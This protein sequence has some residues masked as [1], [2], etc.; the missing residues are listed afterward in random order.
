M[1]QVY[2]ATMIKCLGLRGSIADKLYT[3]MEIRKSMDQ[4]YLATM[5]NL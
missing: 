4:P 3:N 5:T 2:L 1:A